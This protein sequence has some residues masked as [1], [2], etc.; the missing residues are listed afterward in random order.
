MWS[1]V[2]LYAMR[3]TND[4]GRISALC[5][6]MPY[7]IHAITLYSHTSRCVS[8]H[9]HQRNKIILSESFRQ[10]TRASAAIIIIIVIVVRIG[11][12]LFVVLCDIVESF[13]RTD[14][15]IKELIPLLLLSPLFGLHTI[16]SSQRTNSIYRLCKMAKMEKERNRNRKSPKQL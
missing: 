4:A 11:Y 10:R 7:H 5:Q 2:A 1:V 13:I 14:L 15:I 6:F 9:F 3:L 8:L 12:C 16:I